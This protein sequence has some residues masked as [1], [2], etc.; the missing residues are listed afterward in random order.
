MKP[1][2]LLRPAHHRLAAPELLLDL[3]S[4]SASALLSFWPGR[5]VRAALH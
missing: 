3:V 4:F 2:G 5:A 1:L